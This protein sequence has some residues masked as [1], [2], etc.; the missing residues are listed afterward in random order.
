ME[1][2]AS[3]APLWLRPIQLVGLALLAAYYAYAYSQTLTAP[4]PWI[5]FG[6]WQMFTLNEPNASEL[7]VEILTDVGW[8]PMDPDALFPSRWDSGYRY[9]RG[10]FRKSAARLRVLGASTC[11]RYAR[12]H[13]ARPHQVRFIT[14]R[15]R[16]VAGS[17][18]RANVRREEIS[19]FRCGTRVPLPAGRFVP[20][21]GAE[22]S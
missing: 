20:L 3:T 13:D 14:E 21:P 16:K 22:A 6:A 17:M 1:R 9:A 15:W 5:A 11:W 7:R 2:D 19:T 12:A 4:P 8:E 10:S 18:K